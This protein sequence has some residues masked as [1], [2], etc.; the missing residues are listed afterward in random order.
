MQTWYHPEEAGSIGV[1]LDYSLK[2]IDERLTISYS[3]DESY[4][5][6]FD[7]TFESDNT[8]QVEDCGAEYDEFYVIVYH[9]LKVLSEG[10]HYCREANG[11]E[12]T[13]N[14]MPQKVTD[15]HGTVIYERPASA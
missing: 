1:L 2:H 4:L 3:N 12:V 6:C 9:V 13:Y 15:S 8:A 11:I 14:D 10:P 5:C 7:T